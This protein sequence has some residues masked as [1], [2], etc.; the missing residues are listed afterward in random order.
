MPALK[1]NWWKVGIVVHS[2][3]SALNNL[4]LLFSLFNFLFNVL[5]LLSVITLSMKSC[6]FHYF[7]SQTKYLLH[8]CHVPDTVLGASDHPAVT[9]QT[10]ILFSQKLQPGGGRTIA[11]S[12]CHGFLSVHLHFCSRVSHS[13]VDMV[14]VFC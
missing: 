9:E 10:G 14:Y 7:F 11:L 13:G 8:I 4:F 12:R 6:L 2:V 1:V 5:M 3:P